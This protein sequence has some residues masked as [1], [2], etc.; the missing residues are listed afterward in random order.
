MQ[1]FTYDNPVRIHFGEGAISH[2]PE[3]LRSFGS[4]VLLTYGGGSIRKNGIYD[5][6]QQALQQAHKEVYEL[7]GIMPNPRTEKVEEGIALCRQHQIDFILA[8]GGGSVLDCSKAI[9]AGVSLSSNFWDTLFVKRQPLQN[10]LPLGTVLTMAATGSEMNDGCVITNWQ[11]QQKFSYE[12]PALF[13][14]FSILDPTYTY[15]MPKAQM[16]Y[17]CVDIFSHI[18]ETYFSAPN[19]PN[20]SDDLAEALLRNLIE[21]TAVAL[22]DSRD[23]TARANIMW[24]STLAINGLLHLGKAQD[25]MGHQIEHALSAFYDIPH[26]A[27]LAIVHPV[28]LRYICAQRPEKF[29]RFAQNIW[30]LERGDTL[31]LAYAGLERTRQ[32]FHEIGAPITLREVG[33]PESAL[34]AIAEKVYPYPTSYSDLTVSDVRAIL[35]QCL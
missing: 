29:A 13:P 34:D 32:Y 5:A 28:Y 3:E 19:T 9:A 35:Q 16:V 27:G 22:K 6:V 30:R 20:V 7:S 23:Y 15:S 10:A 18:L 33:I 11:T 12:D 24:D 25:W 17:G 1:A 26:G 8:V 4:R 14:R 21:N 2:L 31:S